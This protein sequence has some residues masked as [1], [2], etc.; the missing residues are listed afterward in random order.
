MLTKAEYIKAAR[1]NY[2]KAV[3]IMVDKSGD[4]AQED[5]PFA[6]FRA[7]EAFPALKVSLENGIAVRLVDKFSRITN[8]LTRPALV[9]DESIEQTILDAC[10][11]FNII[12]IY[13]TEKEKENGNEGNEEKGST[14]E[15]G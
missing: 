4:Y 11:Y 13:L 8:L 1:K 10:N 9:K 14:E 5:D 2:E 7:I 15:K 6:N 12:L 3:A